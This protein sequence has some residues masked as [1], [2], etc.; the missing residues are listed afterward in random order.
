[1]AIRSVSNIRISGKGTSG[2]AGK[3]FGGFITN[4]NFDL[5]YSESPSSMSVTID[6]LIVTG[7]PTL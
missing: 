1:M 3:A 4:F 2:E 7:K 5:G 6:P